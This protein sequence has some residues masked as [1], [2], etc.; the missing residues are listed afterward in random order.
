MT[1]VDNAIDDA[2]QLRVAMV[3]QLLREGAITSKA[4]AR[5]MLA[6]PRHAYAPEAPL[7]QVYDITTAVPIKHDSSGITISSVSAA[8]RQAFMLGQANV[9]LGD[10]V[11]EIG[12]MGPFAALLCELVGPNGH[13]T[14]A[15]I[16]HEI[17]ERASGHLKRTGYGRVDVVCAD[18]EYGVP[19]NA[20]YNRIIATVETPDIPPAWLRQLAPGGRIVAPLR[21][22]GVT[23]SVAFDRDSAGLISRS[24][25]VCRFVPMRGDGA[26]THQ[27]LVIDRGVYL[28]VDDADLVLDLGALRQALDGPASISW[29]GAL[30]DPLGE[31]DLFLLTNSPRMALLHASPER[32]SDGLLDPST[33]SGVPV[34]IGTDGSFAYRTQ[35]RPDGDAHACGVIAQ[36]PSAEYVTAQYRQLLVH[37]SRHYRRG[38]MATI[39]YRP[40][41]AATPLGWEPRPGGLLHKRHGDIVVSWP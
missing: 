18:A 26:H 5:A 6:V 39:R 10:R 35:G 2:T 34:L 12:T 13:V 17:V 25:H 38:G 24:Y 27:R 23:R 16:D 9:R 15:D 29:P 8:R 1:T 36:G 33:A 30:C 28:T 32:V 3:D 41:N 31:L 19:S 14:S 37:W 7:E 11:L 4:V 20:P 40:R 21:L 22:K